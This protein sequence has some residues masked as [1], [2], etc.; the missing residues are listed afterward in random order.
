MAV[1]VEV[2]VDRLSPGDST[3]G[4]DVDIDIRSFMSHYYRISDYLKAGVTLFHE[5]DRLRR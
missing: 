5:I 4:D 3:A 2:A 1:A